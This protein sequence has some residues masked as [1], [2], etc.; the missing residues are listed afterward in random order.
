MIDPSASPFE[1]GEEIDAHLGILEPHELVETAHRIVEILDNHIADLASE[2]LE[3]DTVASLAQLSVKTLDLNAG[4]VG[5]VSKNDPTG[6]LVS[7]ATSPQPV[8]N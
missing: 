3:P 7:R 5:V 6:T 8:T 4:M 2:Q 1:A